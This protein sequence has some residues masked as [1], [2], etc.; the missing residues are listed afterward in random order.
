MV[1]SICRAFGG[2]G[3]SRERTSKG[4]MILKLQLQHLA[5]SATA[6]VLSATSAAVAAIIRVSES[7]ILVN[8]VNNDRRMSKDSIGIS[9]YSPCCLKVLFVSPISLWLS[10]CIVSLTVSLSESQLFG[11]NESVTVCHCT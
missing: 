9:L 4:S 3:G 1:K 5:A 11:L 10:P 2:G 6:V 7:F 8:Q